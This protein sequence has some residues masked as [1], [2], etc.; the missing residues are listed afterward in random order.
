[1]RPKKEESFS[2]NSD[3]ADVSREID[4]ESVFGVTLGTGHVE[5]GIFEVVDTG[6]LF[7]E[8]SQSPKTSP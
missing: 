8:L 7:P 2:I 6:F 5:N 1:M 4:A 3:E